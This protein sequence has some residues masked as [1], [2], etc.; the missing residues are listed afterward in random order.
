M[1]NP[2]ENKPRDD[3]LG[4]ATGTTAYDILR[5]LE[6]QARDDAWGRFVDRYAPRIFRVLLAMGMSESEADIVTQDVV[7]RVF[8]AKQS[9]P[10][11]PSKGRFRAWLRWIIRNCF[12]DYRRNQKRGARFVSG[13][14]ELLGQIEDAT[15]REVDDESKRELLQLAIQVVSLSSKRDVEMLLDLTVHERSVAE[16]AEKFGMKPSAVYMAKCRALKKLRAAIQHLMETND[17]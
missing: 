7:V 8:E 4:S 1:P 14:D 16:V 6:G 15:I 10:Y 5:D 3:P 17:Q 13:N 2:H 12:I 9:A 11:D